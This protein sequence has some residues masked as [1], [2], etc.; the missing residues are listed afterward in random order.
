MARWKAKKSKPLGIW[1]SEVRLNQCNSTR[2]GKVEKLL[3]LL[4]EDIVEDVPGNG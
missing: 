3:K 2:K 1:S 4:K